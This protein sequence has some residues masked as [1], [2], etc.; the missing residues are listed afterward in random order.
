MKNRVL[1]VLLSIGIILS[2]FSTGFVAIAEGDKHPAETTITGEIDK[3]DATEIENNNTVNNPNDANNNGSNFDSEVTSTVALSVEFT[4]SFR[5]WIYYGQQ[6]PDLNEWDAAQNKPKY[7]K[8]IADGENNVNISEE[9]YKHISLEYVKKDENSDESP[10]HDTVYSI[11]LKIIEDGKDTIEVDNS[12]YSFSNYNVGELAVKCYSPQLPDYAHT[13][14]FINIDWNNF[15]IKSSLKNYM[16]LARPISTNGL[17]DDADKQIAFNDLLEENGKLQYYICNIDSN[18]PEEYHAISK[19]MSL[20]I[21]SSVEI[22][23]YAEITNNSDSIKS[24]FY[25]K[26]LDFKVTAW[27]NT[28][29]I[30]K[31]DLIVKNADKAITKSSQSN[32]GYDVTKN[33][34]KFEAIYTIELGEEEVIPINLFMSVEEGNNVLD[35]S[36]I[37]LKYGDVT[38]ESGK[39]ILDSVSPKISNYKLG[40]KYW[41]KVAFEAQDADS[42]IEKVTVTVS[43]SSN[44]K[45]FES[46]EEKYYYEFDL[47][48]LNFNGKVRVVVEVVDKAGNSVT[49]TDG[50][51]IVD[52]NPPE[53]KS[54]SFEYKNNDTWL[55]AGNAVLHKYD[56]GRFAKV[57]I[58]I[59]IYAEDTG[60]ENTFSGIKT[61][62]LFNNDVLIAKNY[63]LKYKSETIENEDGS[64]E[65]VETDEVAYYYFEIS[66]C[67]YDNLTIK[68]GD[69]NNYTDK[70]IGCFVIEDK[71]PTLT[72]K[73]ESFSS[74]V[75][76]NWYNVDQMNKSLSFSVSDNDGGIASIKLLD[77]GKYVNDCCF[78]F[79]NGKDIITNKD[80]NVNISD[81]SEG[82][83]KLTLVIADNSGNINEEYELKFNCDF[84]RPSGS[85]KFSD[86]Y[87]MLNDDQKW[88]NGYG[89]ESQTVTATLEFVT[90]SDG[91]RENNPYK[92]EVWFTDKN[93]NVV[94]SYRDSDAL[95]YKEGVQLLVDDIGVNFSELPEHYV[96]VHAVFYDEA[97]NSSSY[98]DENG[99]EV[100]IITERFYKDIA[101]PTI[102]KVTVK[103]TES[104]V[105]K[106]LRILT[107]G[108]YSNNNIRYEIEASDIEFDSGL[109]E[110]AVT[111]SFIEKGTENKISFETTYNGNN[112]YSKEISVD[113]AKVLSGEIFISVKDN[114]GHE[115]TEF[116]QIDGTKEEPY[117]TTGQD[118]TQNHNFTID[119]VLPVVKFSELLSDGVVSKDAPIW[120]TK[121][122]HEIDITVS[123]ADS[124][125]N[126][127][128]F[129]VN[130]DYD[131][132]I[133]IDSKNNPL[134]TE[135]ET[136]M[137]TNVE[138]VIHETT[139][140][141]FTDSLIASSEYFAEDGHYIIEVIAVD[142]AGNSTLN[143][144]NDVN[145]SATPMI[146]YYVDMKEPKVSSIKFS[147]ASADGDETNRE[148][149]YSE[150]EKLEYGYYFKTGFTAT[151][152]VTD[153]FRSS[154][155][156][157]ITYRL[158]SFE[159]GILV[160]EGEAIPCIIGGE[161][162]Y[163]DNREPK[164]ETTSF[165][166]PANFKGRVYLNVYDNVG[167]VRETE[168]S[169]DAL[170]VDTP[171]R[172]ES[173]Q[174]I[175]ITG[176]GDTNYT[177]AEGH[178]LFSSNVN[179]TVRVIDTMSGIR[180]IS[181]S[182]DS[183]NDV[184][185]NKTIVLS[186]TGY[187][188]NQELGDGW[189]ITA[190]DENLVTEVVRNYT[191]SADN[192]NI[193]L[194]IG[195][196]DRSNNESSKQSDIFSVDQTAP[197]INVVFDAPAGNGDCYRA[198]RTATIT[199]IERNFDS[200][201]ITP[202]IQNTFGGTPSISG[203]TDV[204]KTEHTATI[205][206]G[207]GDYTFSIAGTDR[208]DHTATV[209]YSGGNEQN[210]RVDMT[211]P[212][213]VHNFDQ[214][215][216]DAKN[217]FNID[218]EMTLTITEHN[219]VPNMVDIHIYRTAAGQ[220][221]TTSNREECSSE[222]ISAD[223]WTG[224][225]D[226]HTISFTFSSD[227]VYQVVIGGTDE[228]GR[229]ITD[230]T[231]PMFEIDKTKPIL[232]TP[233]NLDVLVY[234]NKNTETEAK[235]IV[236]ED[237]NISKVEYSV[238]SYQMKLNEENV[239]YDMSVDSKKFEA[240]NGTVKIGNEFFNQDGIYEVKCVPYDVAGNAGDESTH[241]YVIQRETDFL[242]YIP[243]SNKENHT[244]LYKFDQTGIRSADFEDIE[245]ISYITKDKTFAVEV[246]GV[247]ITDGD[248]DTKLDERKINQVNMYDVTVKNSYISQ[249]FNEDTVDTDL[250][251]NA[252]AKSDDTSQII[253]LGHIYIDN[254]KPMGEYEKSLQD[255]GFFDGFY[256]V[257]SKTV[258]IEGVS[259]DIDVNRCEIQANDET[260]TFENGG[261]KYDENAHTISF[262]LNKGYTD[263]RPTLVDNAGNIN[264][265]EIIKN[266]YV[267]NLFA[268]W[269]YLFIIG[270]LVILA[271]PTFFIIM[272]VRKK[273]A[274]I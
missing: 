124:G 203:F 200:S 183:E 105:D 76:G 32:L 87:E 136:N 263:I 29:K 197:V 54:V 70:N 196:K 182:L 125:L 226:T 178:P 45:V 114:Y 270:G 218:K 69:G 22:S 155:I 97:G 250:T 233:N 89:A 9:L 112:I 51:K 154:G 98:V 52:G 100:G 267:G 130:H 168:L 198:E 138:D 96:D 75:N 206:F 225:G 95:L 244:G 18:N 176:M 253:T 238:V 17:T 191:F 252:I 61:V 177:D 34:Y 104:G 144:D 175:E 63:K 162:Q 1:S 84:T 240:K 159:N 133:T 254:V 139:Y 83:H 82:V 209:N 264:N 217:S 157:K 211:D 10:E 221:L 185:E 99:Q 15:V 65:I 8:L 188:V 146:E 158:Q 44:R 259:P 28:V 231:S 16:V 88:Y 228:S 60:D 224:T 153:E 251:L 212:V 14:G 205:T 117:S 169:F 171:E 201:R 174:H 170:V 43:D 128:Y 242:V 91:F 216:N 85:I 137:I 47:N 230:T 210:F 261:F 129:V 123:D 131:H 262:T 151:V 19:V 167:N 194:S 248:L 11:V 184:Q 93:G 257:E 202:S 71:A 237:S 74:D 199:V 92:V 179:L 53:I 152:I 268:R 21:S 156:D 119:K 235:P 163:D 164:V 68:V 64:K 59:L 122:H 115:T 160:S 67:N 50:N 36:S 234:T 56:Y 187:S 147:V 113:E 72:T 215:V 132:P 208:C 173:E 161:A 271:I 256:G 80:I 25:N 2:N 232:K 274:I 189:T 219:F 20:N 77:N 260:L 39:F 40:N 265:L 149:F 3:D 57:P 266:V 62:E 258:M 86:N 223:K 192:N 6:R 180:E 94:K 241:T 272:I 141:I 120:I 12:K 236:F 55:T 27:V 30:D 41:N 7:Y 81:F 150:I 127:V 181:Y 66:N 186:N 108:I 207:E 239:G 103:R 190:M 135:N 126:S 118:N 145:K 109:S 220:E 148:E 33:M 204:S 249:N 38:F 13:N 269:W 35:S 245:I 26:S 73:I 24:G 49:Y 111:I 273:R 172:H 255:I 195:M 222:Y 246:D 227:Y 229:V 78:D 243:N 247:E 42:G 90:N 166:I 143:R 165:D 4:E 79:T 213:L 46:N 31:V 121:D 193:Q 102:N 106:V 140:T 214:F 116:S 37:T 142:Y 58:R 5:N 48:N 101:F 134:L 107:F 23:Q 110:S